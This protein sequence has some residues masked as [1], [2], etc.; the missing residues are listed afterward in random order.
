MTTL[1]TPRQSPHCRLPTTWTQELQSLEEGEPT[2][3]CF[4][5]QKGTSG[6]P[7]R[8]RRADRSR[9]AS[10][11]SSLPWWRFTPA[12]RGEPSPSW[13]VGLSAP[14][15]TFRANGGSPNFFQVAG[16]FA[17]AARLQFHARRRA[18]AEWPTSSTLPFDHVLIRSVH[19]QLLRPRPGGFPIVHVGTSVMG[20]LAQARRRVHRYASDGDYTVQHTATTVDGRTASGPPRLCPSRPTT[21]QSP[22][23]HAKAATCVTDALNLQSRSNSKRYPKRRRG[24]RLYKSVQDPVRVGCFQC[25]AF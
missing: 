15:F 22:S 4:N 5:A 10:T 1:P 14:W 3:S 24:S 19:R 16:I 13:A 25:R 9:Q 23:S 17:R 6:T 2:P 8:L 21:W 20:Q 18:G 12:T 11:L 7:L